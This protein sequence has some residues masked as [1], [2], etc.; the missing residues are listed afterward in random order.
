M[1]KY[2][3]VAALCT[4]GFLFLSACGSAAPG[5]NGAVKGTLPPKEQPSLVVTPGIKGSSVILKTGGVFEVR[6]STIPS[7]GFEWMVEKIDNKILVQEGPAVYVA[8]DSPNS[9]GGKTILKFRA[10]APGR[11]VLSLVHVRSAQGDSPAV[12]DDS[13]AVSVEVT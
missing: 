11:T 12:S 4:A 10:L 5:G 2:L 9:A 1:N 8:D 6:I 13:M 7:H 3:K